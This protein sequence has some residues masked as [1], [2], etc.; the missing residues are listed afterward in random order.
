ML[1]SRLVYTIALFA[2]LSACGSSGDDSESTA[3]VSSPDPVTPVEGSTSTADVECMYSYSAFNSSPSVNTTSTADW[4][5]DA[6][7]ADVR[8]HRDL[9]R[10]PRV[11][12]AREPGG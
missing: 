11:V 5:C 8:T 4:F 6:G 10:R 7:L 1:Q 9:S 3:S 2:F 12:S